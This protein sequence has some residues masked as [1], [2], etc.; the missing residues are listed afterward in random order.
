MCEGKTEN[1]NERNIMIL[2]L[3]NLHYQNYMKNNDGSRKVVE[4]AYSYYMIRRSE[5]GEEIISC[6]ETNEAPLK[7]VLATLGENNPLHAV[8]YFATKK[9]RAEQSLPY[10]PAKEGAMN[11]DCF[12]EADFFWK[13]RVQDLIGESFAKETKLIQIDFDEDNEDPVGGSIS[14]VTTLENKIREYLREQNVLRKGEFPLKNCNL[15]VDITGGMRT[16]NMVMS[17]A[18]QL[19]R[20]EGA[21]LKR[22]VYSDFDRFRPTKEG[23]KQP[24]HPVS[25]V[26]PINDM[27]QLV[28]GVDAF[29]KYGSSAALNEYFADVINNEVGYQPLK[30]M[31]FVM[32][33]FSA[34]VLLC[35][36][37]LIKKN[38]AK[39]M[40]RLY[41]FMKEK[42][43]DRPAKVELFARMTN[44][45]VHRY[46]KMLPDMA[47]EP[48]EIEI[49]QWCVDN[50]LIQQALTLCTEWLPEY[51]V[52]H[53]AVYTED[54]S[55]QHYCQ[56][57]SGRDG[58]AV[59]KKHF[60][61]D[62]CTQKNPEIK[63]I[64]DWPITENCYAIVEGKAPVQDDKGYVQKFAQ[65]LR[66]VIAAIPREMHSLRAGKRANN[67][68]LAKIMDKI[69]QSNNKIASND[70]SKEILLKRLKSW[71]RKDYTQVFGQE[72][73][74]LRY[75]FAEPDKE[76]ADESAKIRWDDRVSRT[77]VAV[78]RNMLA[79]GMMCSD[80]SK[81]EALEYIRGYTYI[82]ADLRNKFNHAKG[83]AALQKVQKDIDE[84][85]KLLRKIR[86]RKH[87]YSGLWAEDASKE[88]IH[89]DR[90]PVCQFLE[91]P[92]RPL[93]AGADCG[94]GDVWTRGG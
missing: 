22:V 16:A 19:L 49:I 4:D 79:C 37:N 47:K 34:S 90:F 20:Y 67:P 94:G 14:A 12:S 85:L 7:D 81:E 93:V 27:Y 68:D 58:D 54:Q 8:F 65:R 73:P 46:S 88:A 9:V 6:V 43:S 84:Y 23:E 76:K 11:V 2:F 56:T 74:P 44:E 53:G 38:L 91:P 62:F 55:I 15:Y 69:R 82:R 87:I 71:K 26:Q 30:K 80:V 42:S 57:K 92:G 28:A 66:D 41:K 78:S 50:S 5:P 59:G 75:I 89:H 17:A 48:D 24:I 13:G 86:D 70:L 64:T 36:T 40:R 32:D 31:L 33:K 1:R 77:A 21:A 83:D 29:T 35:Q 39:L 51:L 52:N 10:R 3:S 18:M 60:L 61:M 63:K 72:D 25:N 45:L